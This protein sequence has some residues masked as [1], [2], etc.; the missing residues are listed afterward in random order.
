MATI[1]DLQ[2]DN[3]MAIAMHNKMK[4]DLIGKRVI[5]TGGTIN[6]IPG[7]LKRIEKGRYP[8]IVE[9][10]SGSCY[11]VSHIEDEK[12]YIKRKIKG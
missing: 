1:I 9:F 2:N 10:D 12:E 5:A 4:E 11:G 8:Y 6:P 3:A 7:I